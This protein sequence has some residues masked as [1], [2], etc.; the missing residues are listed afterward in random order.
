MM[1][2]FYRSVTTFLVV[3]VAALGGAGCGGVALA[4]DSAAVMLDLTIEFMD[5]AYTGGP[6]IL[7]GD[8]ARVHVLD[9]ALRA[10]L[11]GMEVGAAPIPGA[12]RKVNLGQIQVRMRQQ[13]IDPAAFT[14]CGPHEVT[15]T[16]AAQR[17]AAESIEQAAIAAVCAD[18][19]YVL[20]ELDVKVVRFDYPQGLTVPPGPV[21][22]EA[23]LVSPGADAALVRANVKVLAGGTSVRTVSVWMQIT[24]PPAILRGA[25]VLL[26]ALGPGVSVTVPAVALENGRP[27]QHIRVRNAVSAAEVAG[28]VIDSGTVQVTLG[29]MGGVL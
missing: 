16:A 9:D 28:R 25:A 15:V 11:E 3:C 2:H 1:R 14:F 27:G 23:S 21:H 22:L 10:Q 12:A 4:E 17:V 6:Q 13:R 24:A 8:I 7:L 18:A 26:V 29:A 20:D 19:G 5:P